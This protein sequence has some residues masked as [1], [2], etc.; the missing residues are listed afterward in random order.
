[1]FSLLFFDSTIVD[2]RF[3]APPTL[4]VTSHPPTVNPVIA[5]D[6]FWLNFGIFPVMW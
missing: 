6:L 5:T 3:F 4:V 1:M 2:L